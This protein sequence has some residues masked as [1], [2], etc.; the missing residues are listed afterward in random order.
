M[1]QTITC[2]LCAAE[3]AAFML[4][5]LTDGSTNSV[6]AGCAPAFITGLAQTVGLVAIPADAVPVEMGGT[7]V[8]D[9]TPTEDTAGAEKP[10]RGRRGA[11]K[12]LSTAAGETASLPDRMHAAADAVEAMLD[13][14]DEE[15]DEP[16]DEPTD[17]TGESVEVG[18]P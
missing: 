16:T 15:T 11:R 4:T 1:G 5:S 17:R 13:P 10:V 12:A 7:L 3:E 6:G 8:L 2:D 9:A 14:V 18:A